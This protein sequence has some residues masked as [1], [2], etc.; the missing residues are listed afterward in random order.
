[1]VRSVERWVRDFLFL[2]MFSFRTQILQNAA[3]QIM[4]QGNTVSDGTS[5]RGGAALGFGNYLDNTSVFVGKY[6][7]PNMFLQTMV[8]L[9]YDENR[10]AAAQG[11]LT[12][13]GYAV[14]A[15]IGFELRTPWMDVRLSIVPIHFE[16]LFVDDISV[17]LIWRRSFY[18]LKDLFN[19]GG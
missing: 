9:R 11:R 6:L 5:S 7:D 10:T 18:G 12:L 19:S 17:S 4:G 16:H 2:D 14:E 3:L 1:M 13:G 8:S 15:D